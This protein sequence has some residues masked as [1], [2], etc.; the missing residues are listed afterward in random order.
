MSVMRRLINRGSMTSM[1]RL[2]SRCAIPAVSKVSSF[3]T[4]ATKEL[5]DEGAFIRKIEGQREEKARAELERILA[6]DNY[7]EEKKELMERLDE[8]NKPETFASKYGLDDW[9]IAAPIGAL[10]FLPLLEGGFLIIDAE[11]HLACVTALCIGTFYTQFGPSISREL[12]ASC[13]EIYEQMKAVDDALLTGITSAIENNEMSLSLHDDFKE[14][15]AVTDQVAAAQAEVANHAE[16]HHYRDAI[17]KKLD[18]LYA[19]EEAASSAIRQRMINKV[20][21]DVVNSFK[22]DRK[23]KEDALASAMAVLASGGVKMGKDVVGMAFSSALKDY[24]ET[25][26]KM[27]PG[28]DEI[29]VGLEKDM[30]LV[31]MAPIPAGKGGNV[32]VM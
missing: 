1:Q 31:A 24:K 10:L 19:L 20:K 6:M 32:Y 3:S 28:S 25:Y 9:K 22:T 27:A 15:Y 8:A 11:F 17:V 2:S 26:T 4:L 5:G 12:N 13:D 16:A 29:L 7:S 30:A 23:V 14:L 18:S 21:G